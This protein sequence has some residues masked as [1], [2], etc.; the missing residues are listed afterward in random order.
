VY[1]EHLQ[2]WHHQY[3]WRSLAACRKSL[4]S[5]LSHAQKFI[6]ISSCLLISIFLLSLQSY[7]KFSAKSVLKLFE[8]NLTFKDNH[9]IVFCILRQAQSRIFALALIDSEVFA[10]V[11]MNKFFTQQHHF[12]LHQL[13]HSCRLQE[14]DDQVTLINDITHVIEI[15]MILNK[16]IERL[17]F[18]VIELSQYFIIMSLSWLHHHVIDVNF[19]HNILIL[20][21]FFYLNHCCSSLI[22]IYDFNQQEENFLFEVN[23]VTFFQSHSQFTH[24]KQLS[25]W[26]TH[27]KQFN[28]QIIH[29]K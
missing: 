6:Y 24:K 10:Y 7:R 14:F 20:S 21:F 26:I 11:F 9:M 27:K 8:F 18:Y 5:E 19:E 13:I 4:V 1:H 28:L 22:K 29:K 23:K 25:S 2:Q 16:H 17:F 3:K 15:T 12:F